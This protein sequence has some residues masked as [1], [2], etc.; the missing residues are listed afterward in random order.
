MLA[1]LC[2]HIIN[3]IY[4]L[5]FILTI[6]SVYL[7]F[8][9]YVYLYNNAQII[10]GIFTIKRIWSKQNDLVKIDFHKNHPY[11]RNPGKTKIN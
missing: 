2:A 4:K 9:I 6:T 1:L 10:H 5:Y 7:N 8:A 11:I 3:T